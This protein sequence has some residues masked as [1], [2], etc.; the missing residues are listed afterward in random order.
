MVEYSLLEKVLSWIV[1]NFAFCF[2]I[3]VT[4]SFTI[5]VTIIAIVTFTILF[6]CELSCTGFRKPHLLKCI[7]SNFEFNI[8]RNKALGCN[9]V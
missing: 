8:A 9:L 5:A 2:S 3:T 4:V 1:M 7:A 6:F